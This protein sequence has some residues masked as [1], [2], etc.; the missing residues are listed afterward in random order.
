MRQRGFTLIELIAVLVIMVTLAVVAMGSFNP[1]DYQLSAARD[2]L[3]GALRYAQEMSLSH[4]GANDYQVTLTA[5]GY[6]VTQ[7]GV[8]IPHPLTGAG[9]YDSN[10]S[11][12]VLDSTGTIGFDGYGEPWLGGG[13]A[14]GGNQLSVTLS[15]GNASGIVRVER[16]TGFVR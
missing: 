12:V 13:L 3:V 11:N 10:W 5:G 16:V 15:V 1:N 4:T 6:S 2:E 7:A 14:W 8:P 9:S